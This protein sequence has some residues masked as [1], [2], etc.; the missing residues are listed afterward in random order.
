MGWTS[1]ATLQAKLNAAELEKKLLQKQM[2]LERELSQTQKDLALELSQKQ[3]ELELSQKK[4]V[5]KDLEKERDLAR[6]QLLSTQK[7]LLTWKSKHQAV[8]AERTLIEVGLQS[9]APNKSLTQGY[10]SF[11]QKYVFDGGGKLTEDAK[12]AFGS[13]DA[14]TTEANVKKELM[15][16]PHE[17]SKEKHHLPE[18]FAETGLVVGGG[19]PLA[20]AVAVVI[21]LLQQHRHL[22]FAVTYC[23]Q[24]FT[25]KRRLKDGKA[26]PLQTIS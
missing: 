10:A 1:S 17:L 9:F 8:L 25:P 19:E 16:L 2:E 4:L 15:Y 22:S 5:Q 7:E 6:N 26:L 12:N 3:K 14:D 24:S 13:L 21:L 23:D 11:K 20:S 18:H